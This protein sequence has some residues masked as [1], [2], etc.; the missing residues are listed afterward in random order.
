MEKWN[1]CLKICPCVLPHFQCVMWATSAL[2][3]PDN[4]GH[5]GLLH[6]EQDAVYQTL[7]K[8]ILTQQEITNE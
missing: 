1:V 7:W 3:L 6:L 5:F 4:W 8:D 2:N